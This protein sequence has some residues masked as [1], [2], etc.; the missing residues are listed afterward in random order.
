MT[1]LSPRERTVLD[2]SCTGLSNKEIARRL[3]ITPGTIKTHMI[4]IYMKMG[5]R[6]RIEAMAKVC[7]RMS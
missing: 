6:N 5:V 7:G 2:L 4:H 1:A 3:G